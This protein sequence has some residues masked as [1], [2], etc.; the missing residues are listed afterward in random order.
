[1]Q[2]GFYEITRPT[3]VQACKVGRH[4]GI[5]GPVGDG[6]RRLDKNMVVAEAEVVA[7][8][9]SHEELK[10]LLNSLTVGGVELL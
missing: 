6:Y 5:Y 4:V 9:Q 7:E 10:T 3:I 8:P 1:M 2:P